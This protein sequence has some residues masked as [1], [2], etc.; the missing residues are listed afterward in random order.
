[1]RREIVDAR[2]LESLTKI[3]LCVRRIAQ[4]ALLGGKHGIFLT[5]RGG[6]AAV[7]EHLDTPRRQSKFAPSGLGLRLRLDDQT[8][9]FDPN[10]GAPDVNRRGFQ[11]DGVPDDRRALPDAEPRR[12]H[13]VDKVEQ[14]TTDRL[15]V[16]G[17]EGA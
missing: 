1:M 10:H 14:I 12:D 3:G 2:A 17:Q 9:A 5:S 4:A 13:H 15:V 16:I 11:V 6:R 7:L 8:L